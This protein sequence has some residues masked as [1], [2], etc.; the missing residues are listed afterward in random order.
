VA[1]AAAGGGGDGGG[2]GGGV[3]GKNA[4][5]TQF[6]GAGNGGMLGMR[7]GPGGATE[8]PRPAAAAAES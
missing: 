6:S 4:G 2:D 7:I 1:S 3:G 5:R 8:T